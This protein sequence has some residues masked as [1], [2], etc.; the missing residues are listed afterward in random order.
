MESAVRLPATFD[1]K[2]FE[3]FVAGRDEPGWVTDARR[4]AFAVFQEK[5]AEPLDPEGVERIH[6]AAMHILSE[7]G[8]EFLNPEALD[9]ME[10]ITTRQREWFDL[11]TLYQRQ[12]DLADA[13]RD[14]GLC[15]LLQLLQ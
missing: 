3:A 5:S 6:K 13:E 10:R 2:A 4:K 12:A 1:E 8:I 11:V 9:A 15:D 7:I 14:E